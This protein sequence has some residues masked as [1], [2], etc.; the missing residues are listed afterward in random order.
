MIKNFGDNLKTLR[1]KMDLT[2]DE[3]SKILNVSAQTISRWETGMGYP[4][5]E[6]FPAIANFYE[7][8][9]DS[10]LCIDINKKKEKITQIIDQINCLRTKG[11]ITKCIEICRQSLKEFPNDFQILSSLSSCLFNHGETVEEIKENNEEVIGLCETILNDCKDDSIRHLAIL[12]LCHTYPQFDKKEKAL[13][14]AKI[15]PNYFITSNELLNNILSDDEKKQH[16]HGNLYFLI[17]IITRNIEGLFILS[18]DSEEKINILNSLINIYKGFFDKEDYYFF[19]CL[20]HPIY[21]YM[22]AI[23]ADNK[24]ADKAVEYVKKSAYHAIEYDI[25][26]EKYT[27]TSSVFLGVEDSIINSITNSNKNNSW[28]LLNKLNDERYDF[29][30]ENAQFIEIIDNLKQLV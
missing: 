4:D 19:H 1:R 9:V 16:I 30:R 12:L 17:Q 20:I 23:Y 6:M 27:F 26:P 5:I 29:I 2:Q 7:V 3:V 11:E 24:N 8:S 18:K 13:E 10:L 14:M 21:R 22:A 28:V 25:R 15:M